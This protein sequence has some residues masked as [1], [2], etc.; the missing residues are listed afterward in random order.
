MHITVILDPARLWA[1]H[2]VLLEEIARQ[3]GLTAGVVFSRPA[4][5]L[6]VAVRTGLALERRL[7]PYN[8][9]P[10][11]APLAPDAFASWTA[12]S[13]PAGLVIDL[14][15]NGAPAL[16]GPAVLAPVYDGHIGET[17]LWA[18][19]L[20]GTSPRLQLHDSSGSGLLDIGQPKTERPLALSR[21]A[22][23]VV[24]RLLPA[25][26]RAATEPAPRR[27]LAIST[28]GLSQDPL[29][30]LAQALAAKAVTFAR[31]TAWNR[32]VS[33]PQWIVAWRHCTGE[34][35]HPG[36]LIPDLTGYHTC[37]LYTSPSP[38][39]GLLSRMPSSA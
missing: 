8:V 3:T 11:M 38:R 15:A 2:L 23:E 17:A 10:A 16:Q 25:L 12:A 26:V 27:G 30:N 36:A 7:A 13:A 28:G 37:L 21:S 6:P 14:A 24:A 34:I 39:D 31:R 35:G 4:Q 1:W 9:H 18:A 22:A 19:L 32:A 33:E 20:K 5:P 29:P